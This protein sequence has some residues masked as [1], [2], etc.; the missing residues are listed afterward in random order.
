MNL[1]FNTENNNIN[2]DI[3]DINNI[4]KEAH[5]IISKSNLNELEELRSKAKIR[6]IICAILGIILIIGINF[7][8]GSSI[9]SAIFTF[10]ALTGGVIFAG[11]PYM[12]YKN[13]YKEYFVQTSLKEVFDNLN[14]Q[15]NQGISRET[16]RNTKMMQMGDKYSSNDYIEADYNGVHFVQSDVWIQEEHEDA[17][18]KGSHSVTLFKGRWMIFDFN[19][20]FKANVQV[21]QSGF[22]NAKRKRLFGKKEELYKK[23]EMED[24]SF[25]KDFKVFAQNE[26]DAFYILTPSMMDRI[27]KITNNIE[28]KLIF[29]FI[30]N[31]LHI[32]IH[33]GKDS[34]E[35]GMMKKI[36]PEVEKE[37]I[38]NDINLITTFVNELSLDTKLFKA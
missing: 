23:V 19:K 12:D 36:D 22:H 1:K 33:T 8:F 7:I 34:F 25:N 2:N 30:E 13:K 32:G 27:R 15:P 37:K 35:P 18:G 24:V 38:V 28:G 9:V 11:K 26:H 31:Q 10:G 20:E 3:N 16:I 4:N 17:D 21:V 5:E 6:A 29:C 14:Y